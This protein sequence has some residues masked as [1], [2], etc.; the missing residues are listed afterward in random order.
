MGMPPQRS[1]DGRFQRRASDQVFAE[2]TNRDI[3]DS[4]ESLRSEVAGIDRRVSG[5][6]SRIRGFHRRVALAVPTATVLA[7]AA[8]IYYSFKA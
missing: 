3:L 4:V 6:E 5:L 1:S 2:I 7:S 8:T